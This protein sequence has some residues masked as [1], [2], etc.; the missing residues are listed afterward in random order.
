MISQEKQSPEAEK[1]MI[2]HTGAECEQMFKDLTLEVKAP[3]L[4]MLRTEL[5]PL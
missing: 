4:E 2:C 1:A 3:A 5:A